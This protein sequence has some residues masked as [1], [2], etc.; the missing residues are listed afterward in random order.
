MREETVKMGIRKKMIL[1][2][3]IVGAFALITGILGLMILGFST[4]TNNEVLNNYALAQVE[5]QALLAHMDAEEAVMR[6]IIFLD[7]DG[8]IAQAQQELSQV[9]KAIEEDL[10]RIEEKL[11][12]DTEQASFQQIT[13]NLQAYREAKKNVTG[14]SRQKRNDEALT[15]YREVA[16][17]LKDTIRQAAET[18]MAEKVAQSNEKLAFLEANQDLA[19]VL[20]IGVIIFCFAGAVALGLVVSK[21]ICTSLNSLVDVML[22]LA[23]GNLDVDIAIPT[24]ADEI[25]VL[26]H[27]TKRFVTGLREVIEDVSDHLGRIA[28]GDLSG[29]VTRVYRGNFIEVERSLK[30]ILES[31]NDTLAQI[32]LSSEQ[33]STGAGNV[34]DASQSLSRGATEQGAE[35][36]TLRDL[37]E[38]VTEKAAQSNETAMD[39]DRASRMANER[40]EECGRK[41]ES[42]MAS[43]EQINRTS[44]D[45]EKI[46]KTIEDL[47]FQTNILALNAA[48]EAARAGAAG[49]GFAVVADEVRDLANKSAEAAK[50]TAQLIARTMHSVLEGTKAADETAQAM[51][52]AAR[53]IGS[54]ADMMGAV[55][56]VSTQQAELL[57]DTAHRVEQIAKVVLSNSAAAEESAATSEELSGQARVLKELIDVFQLRQDDCKEMIA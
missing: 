27:S 57:L 46:N 2:Y 19:R 43:M 41:M 49:K 6:D 56:S 4:Q 22:E 21:K 20:I 17:P 3:I 32:H 1:S 39:I 18:L 10:A 28:S 36:E 12:G 35:I 45:I 15:A 8:E 44:V 11:I 26:A 47:A 51:R 37:T 24:E 52:M 29:E 9:E 55:T 40:M 7:D 23:K 33:V 16:E 30:T 42:L 34:A 54:V 53:E 31:L 38:Q 14:L 50:N 25:Q 13:S 5:V 48:V